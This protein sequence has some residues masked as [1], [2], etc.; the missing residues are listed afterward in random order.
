MD[1]QQTAELKRVTWWGVCIN[2][3]LTIVKFILGILGAS[4]AVVA[5]AVHS[6]SDLIT[7]FAVLLGLRYWSAPPDE[8]HP[9]GHQ[10]IESLIT[11]LIGILL[12][13]VALGIGYSAIASVR[14]PHIVQTSWVAVW[15]PFL[16]IFIKEF[17]YQW[18]VKVGGRI[19]SAAAVANAWHHRSD[20]LSSIPA[21]LAVV[22]A[23]IKPEWAF[24]DH[25]G[26][27]VVTVFIFKVAVDILKPALA[28]LADH[29]ASEAE[30]GEIERIALSVEGVREVHKIR[31][32]R[33]GPHIH[34]DL[35]I[36]VDPGITVKEG[37]AISEQ[38]R[39]AL[40]RQG[41][42]VLD[43][44]AHIEPF[45]HDSSYILKNAAREGQRQ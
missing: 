24:I 34:T 4:Q 36:L 31:S 20:A 45:D 29:G 40:I 26:A 33:F 35:H 23:A 2:I 32:R 37:H 22:M 9:Y 7:D 15:G 27:L 25:V 19:K 18:T 8:H 43:V 44:V 42:M 11:V 10:R 3:F 13:I 17:L 5:D 30:R 12:G 38:V 28:E 14:E 39:T 6:L 16:S 1:K 41:P 21:L